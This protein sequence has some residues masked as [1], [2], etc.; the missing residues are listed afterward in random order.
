MKKGRSLSYAR[1]HLECVPNSAE[2]SDRAKI[3]RQ[4]KFLEFFIL[5]LGP[6]KAE[7]VSPDSVLFYRQC[8]W[9]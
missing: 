3:H 6:A 8:K 2:T 7:G 1:K 9:Q 4:N 5:P